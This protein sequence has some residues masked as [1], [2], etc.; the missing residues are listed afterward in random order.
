M[1]TYVAVKDLSLKVPKDDPADPD[2]EQQ[3]QTWAAG[4]EFEPPAHMNI[5]KGVERG[6]IALPEPEADKADE[7]VPVAP[8]RPTS[9]HERADKGG[10]R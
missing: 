8:H 6:I 9:R 3:W 1:T 5:A 10:S 2:E 7:A 4:T